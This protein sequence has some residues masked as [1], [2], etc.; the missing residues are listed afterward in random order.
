MRPETIETQRLQLATMGPAFLRASLAG[1]TARAEA[2]LDARLPGE[3]PELA[4]VLRMRLRQ[5][6]DAPGLEPWLTR[7]VVLAAERRVVG[8]CGFHG[9][10]G[11]DWLRD[12]APGGVEF[13]YT[14]FPAD[15]R[16]GFATEAGEALVR[17]ASETHGVRRYLLSIGPDNVVSA[18]VA[19]RLGF[20]RAGTWVHEQRGLEH[21]WLRVTEP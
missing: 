2:L 7:A 3:W 16:R 14:I 9:P 20:R 8:V 17:W 13:G 12:F 6:D 10:P 4:P 15:R 11:G 5:L 1:D 21:V 18:A 19:T